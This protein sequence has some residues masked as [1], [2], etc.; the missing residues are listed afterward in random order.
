MIKVK[1]PSFEVSDW[2][3][4]S[5]WPEVSLSAT[6]RLAATLAPLATNGNGGNHCT[7]AARS[8]DEIRGSER[9]EET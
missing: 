7:N 4:V 6:L 1:R 3:A 5:R 9:S 2:F 8:G